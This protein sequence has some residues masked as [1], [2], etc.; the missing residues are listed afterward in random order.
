METNCE[1][2]RTMCAALAS[3]TGKRC[4]RAA[5][6]DMDYCASHK[7]QQ[8]KFNT[9]RFTFLQPEPATPTESA[10]LKRPVGNGLCGHIEKMSHDPALLNQIKMAVAAIKALLEEH[11]SRLDEVRMSDAENASKEYPAALKLHGR[12]IQSLARE[13]V[14]AIDRISKIEERERKIMTSEDIRGLIFNIRDR[15][16]KAVEDAAPGEPQKDLVGR[17]KDAFI[18][19]ESSIKER[20]E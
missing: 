5:L 2:K 9:E 12:R 19:I 20:W 14:E 11:L 15:V 6:P 16:I 18:E 13:W 3:R 4:G 7:K 8:E 17:L 10:D 1:E